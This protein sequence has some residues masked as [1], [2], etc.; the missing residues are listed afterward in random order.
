MQWR[1]IFAEPDSCD[2]KVGRYKF[3]TPKHLNYHN[4][5]IDGVDYRLALELLNRQESLAGRCLGQL[6]A[7]A[8]HEGR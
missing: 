7:R 5:D 1:A 8:M 4:K 6:S 3:D 2:G